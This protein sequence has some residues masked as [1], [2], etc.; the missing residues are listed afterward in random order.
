VKADYQPSKDNH[1]RVSRGERVEVLEW[2]GANAVVL[3]G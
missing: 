1:L 3:K 2:A